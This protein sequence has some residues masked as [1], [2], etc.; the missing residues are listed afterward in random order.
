MESLADYLNLRNENPPEPLEEL[1]LDGL[2]PKELAL[3]I[4]HSRE[5]YQYVLNGL[6]LGELPPAIL[7]RLMDY[8][9]GKPPERVEHTGANGRPIESMKIVRVIIDPQV[10]HDV[11]DVLTQPEILH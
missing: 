1:S 5:F 11:E 10:D 2:T 9:W 3:K 7:T 6:T 8:A 4:L